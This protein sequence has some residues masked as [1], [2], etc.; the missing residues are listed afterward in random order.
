[1]SGA[2][3]ARRLGVTQPAVYQAVRRGARVIKKR[4]LE[5]KG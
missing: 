5:L 2:E 1:M 4:H 3:E